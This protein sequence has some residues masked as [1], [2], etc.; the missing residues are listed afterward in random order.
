MQVA[1][2]DKPPPTPLN[3]DTPQINVAVSS[4]SGPYIGTY[5]PGDP[6]AEGD[7][8]PIVRIQ[9]QYPREALLEGTEGWVRMEFTITEDGSV[10]DVSVIESQPRRLFDRNAVRA[11]LRWKFKPR[12]IDGQAVARRAEQT[13]EFK[14][15]Q[16]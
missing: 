9:P 13:I 10:K 11:I 7:I 15:D 8:I 4:G 14:L 1:S 6:A 5:T 2:Q 12:V 3:I 16:G